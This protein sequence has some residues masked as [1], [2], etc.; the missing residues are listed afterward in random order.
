M[1]IIVGNSVAGS[2]PEVFLNN[3]RGDIVVTGEGEISA[4]EAV[5]AVR[6]EKDLENCRR[7]L[8]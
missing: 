8:I 5:E 7:N 6:L 2:I 1:C 4:Y 3:T